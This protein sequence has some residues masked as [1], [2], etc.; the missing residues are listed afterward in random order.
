M[1]RYVF[2]HLRVLRQELGLTRDEVARRVGGKATAETI[3]NYERG[4]RTPSVSRLAELAAALR[5]SP[6]ELFEPTPGGDG[7]E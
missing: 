2:A 1:H 6:G 5:V 7:G 3:R 4:T